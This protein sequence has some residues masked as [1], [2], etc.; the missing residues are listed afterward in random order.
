[1][2]TM[3]SIEIVDEAEFKKALFD[4]YVSLLRVGVELFEKRFGEK[5]L[6]AGVMD[7]RL[8]ATLNMA[9]IAMLAVIKDNPVFSWLGEGS[10]EEAFTKLLAEWKGR[11]AEV[12]DEHELPASPQVH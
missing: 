6:T 4:S 12:L 1:M 2:K 3:K 7:G 9:C 8:E 5:P 11:L 10:P